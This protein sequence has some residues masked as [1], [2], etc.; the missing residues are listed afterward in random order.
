MQ[1]SK[2]LGNKRHKIIADVERLIWQELFNVARCLKTI[3]DAAEAIF[4]SIP[5]SFEDVDE[6]TRS[7]F[8][9]SKALK[10]AEYS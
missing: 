7:W 1:Y 8:L 9:L 5:S 10:Y 4:K 6:E 3:E 2:A